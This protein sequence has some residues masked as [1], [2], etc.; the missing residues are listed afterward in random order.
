MMVLYAIT[1]ALLLLEDTG[2]REPP[3]LWE[4]TGEGG[5]EANVGVATCRK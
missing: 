1:L 5:T 2:L 3:L 4:M